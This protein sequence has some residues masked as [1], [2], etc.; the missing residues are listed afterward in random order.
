MYCWQQTVLFIYHTLCSR[1]LFSHHILCNVCV[2]I[3][4]WA[5]E[6]HWFM[7]VSC[8]LGVKQMLI[9]YDDPMLS[10]RGFLCA[11]INCHNRMVTQVDHDE[12]KFTKQFVYCC[13]RIIRLAWSKLIDLNNLIGTFFFFVKLLNGI[14][15]FWM[16]K[17]LISSLIAWYC[18]KFRKSHV[19]NISIFLEMDSKILIFTKIPK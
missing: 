11:P 7:L 9:L 6:L 2:V 14:F 18:R 3:S 8:W 1:A 17:M 12:I 16:I 19:F 13:V 15:M 5:L 10:L 4:K